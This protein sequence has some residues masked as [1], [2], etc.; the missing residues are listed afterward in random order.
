MSMFSHEIQPKQVT[1]SN[2]PN[3]KGMQAALACLAELP[4]R[5]QAILGDQ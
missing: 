4:G 2:Y 5:I 3:N 1:Y